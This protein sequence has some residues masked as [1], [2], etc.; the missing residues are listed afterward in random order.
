[1][2]E[3]LRLTKI[4]LGSLGDSCRWLEGERDIRN[5]YAFDA[6]FIIII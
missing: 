5:C 2:D 6:V 4:I 1:M 3:G